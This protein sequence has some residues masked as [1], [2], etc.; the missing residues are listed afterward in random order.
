MTANDG[1]TSVYGLKDKPQIDDE[2]NELQ[3]VY[4]FPH[5]GW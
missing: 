2:S 3:H 4:V 1:A 5:I